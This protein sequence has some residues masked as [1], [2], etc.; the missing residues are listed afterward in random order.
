MHDKGNTP[1]LCLHIPAMLLIISYVLNIEAFFEW[2]QDW[3]N[4]SDI[5]H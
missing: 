5:G 3:F 1:I 4:V 2:L